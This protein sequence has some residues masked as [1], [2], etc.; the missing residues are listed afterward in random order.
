M[1]LTADHSFEANNALTINFDQSDDAAHHAHRHLRP[2]C[3]AKDEL[4]AMFRLKRNE[5]AVFQPYKLDAFVSS[6][7]LGNLNQRLLH[8]AQRDLGR[9][10]RAAYP[11]L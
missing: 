11:Q 5:N 8:H 7:R 3:S 2:I 1:Y 6:L 4:E 9:M 10:R